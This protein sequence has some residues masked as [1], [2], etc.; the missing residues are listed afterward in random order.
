MANVTLRGVRK[1]FGGME[2]I[3]GVDLDIEDN[4]LTVFVG[5]SGCGKST[6]LRLIAGLEDITSGEMTIDGEQ[7]QR[8]A[9]E[10][11]RHLHGVPELRALPAYERLRQ[12]GVRAEAGERIE[13]RDRRQGAGGGAYPPD[14]EPADAKAKGAFRRAAAAGRDRAGHRAGA[15]GVPVRR[16][17]VQSGCRVAGADAH[18]AGEAEGGPVSHDGLCDARSGR[19]HDA[20]EQDR[21]AAAPAMSSRSDRRW[22]CT[23]IRATCSSR[24]SSAARR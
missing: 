11:A 23:T 4:E 16:A 15:E 14:R 3:H 2:I 13:G 7:G 5:P 20:G 17:A 22:N 10:G 24:A 18:R 12:H 19:G 9:A 1:S 21:R 6:L 8:P